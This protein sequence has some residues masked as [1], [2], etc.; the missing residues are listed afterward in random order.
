MRSGHDYSGFMLKDKTGSTKKNVGL[1]GSCKSYKGMGRA[2]PF[3]VNDSGTKPKVLGT[4]S[5]D[6]GL[7]PEGVVTDIVGQ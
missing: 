2:M 7:M 3:V 5:R 1:Q 6:M 4:I